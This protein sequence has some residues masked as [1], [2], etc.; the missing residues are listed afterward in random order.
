MGGAATRKKMD[1]AFL[2]DI[3]IMTTE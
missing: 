3:D 1:N 2:G